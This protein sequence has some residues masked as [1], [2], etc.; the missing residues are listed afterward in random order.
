MP[1]LIILLHAISPVMLCLLINQLALIRGNGE[2]GDGTSSSIQNPTHDYAV[3]GSYTVQLTVVNNTTG[4]DYTKQDTLSV[5]K[6]IAD[7]NSS[8][9]SV[10]KNAPVIFNAINSIPGNVSSYTWRFGDG[11]SISG[12]S[13]T[14]NHAYGAAGSYNVTMILKTKDGCSDSIV[15]PLAMQVDG[16]TAVF[17]TLNPGACLNSAIIFIDSSYANGAHSISQWQWNWG[18]GINQTLAA[19]P[20]QHTYALAGSYSVS[21]KVTEDNGCTDS[22]IHMNT[23]VISKPVAAFKGDT[24]SCTLNGVGFTNLS[25]GPALKYFWNFGDG[26]TS[27]Q[28]NPRHTYS[29]E[30]IY[31]VSLNVTDAYGCTDFNSK[32]NYVRIADPKADFRVSDTVGTC[33]PLIVNFTNASKNYSYLSW[34]FGDGTNSNSVNPSHFYA[35]PG[36]FHAVLTINGA[37]GCTD[38]K[39]VQILVKG[40]RGSFSYTNISGC[41]PLQTNF[42]ATTGKNINFVWDFSDGNTIQ[43]PDS[44]VTH[45][46]KTAG[47]YLPKMILV[48]SSGCKVPVTGS[49][50]IRVYEVIASFTN[51]TSAFC[52]SAKVL[53]TNTSTGNDMITNYLWD[54][55]DKS[56]STLSD[57]VHNYGKTGNYNAKLFIT[58][59]N[60][61]KDSVTVNTAVKIVNSPKIAIGGNAGACTPAFLTFTGVIS[62]PDTSALKWKWDFANG[63]VSTL[64]NPPAQTFLNAGS[65]S[66]RLISENSSGCMDTVIKIATAYP[67]PDLDITKDTAICLKSSFNLRATDAQTYSWSPAT[68]LSCSNCATPLCRPDSSIKYFL[69]GTSNKGCFS[70]DSVF[71]DVK[72]PNTVKVNGPDTLCIGSSVQLTAS[73]AEVYS[74]YPSTGLDDPKKASPLAAPGTTTIYTVTGS[75]TKGCFTS[76]ASVPV[77]VY[78]IPVVTAGGRSNN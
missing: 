52:D 8:V 17:K 74:W 62:V 24:L 37:G 10:C 13:N 33:P 6:E 38:Q 64:Q 40:P 11:I 58:S 9:T 31:T 65:Y 68:Y 72:F 29:A 4:C 44:L 34:D 76:T 75:D 28:T 25:S 63:N 2:F 22:I 39:S 32:T 47:I 20:F 73:G 55:G 78:P 69:K 26:I 45:T 3:S 70:S 19:Q 48:D 43:T 46:Y 59:R 21:L 18:D 23:V 14:I 66:V 35:T 71:V 27:T 15:K 36:L 5:F 77:K 49:D 67:L 57:P 54:F 53:F 51:P 56:T 42:K 50:S 41:K 60:G 1:A 30:G 61:C 16:P 7:F 12:N